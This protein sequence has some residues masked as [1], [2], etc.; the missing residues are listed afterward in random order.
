MYFVIAQAPIYIS[1]SGWKDTLSK[2]ARY[3]LEVFK[4]V[5]GENGTLKEPYTDLRPNPVPIN[6]TEFN[7][8]S[9]GAAHSFTFQPQEPGVYSWI[10]E[11]NDR[12]NNSRYLRRFVIYDPSST[13]TS[14][15]THRFYATSGNAASDFKWQ[16]NNPQTVSFTWKNHFLNELHESGNFLAR[17]RLF[18]ASLYD[19]FRT[20]YKNIPDQFDDTEGKRSRDAIP[21]ERGI[22]K[23]DIAYALGRNQLTPQTYQY[24][25]RKN[26][27]IVISPSQQLQ[28]GNS[29]T[30]WVKAYD[31]LD[32]TKEERYI[33]HYDSTGPTL[34]SH[35]LTTNVGSELMDFSS[36]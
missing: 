27:S 9:E 6:I 36:R 29:L 3:A 1:W 35:E 4:L 32:N 2:V 23:Y 15:S 16:I 17:I 11:V 28:D 24:I 31:I 30:L 20:G 7:E 18:P 34:Y 13:V 33:L 12:A 22:I 26:T 19:G 10:L 8:T 5:K 14:D 25:G 21:N